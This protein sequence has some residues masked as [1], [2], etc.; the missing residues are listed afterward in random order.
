MARK[1]VTTN[2][3]GA[4]VYPVA[5][6]LS[7]LCMYDYIYICTSVVDVYASLCVCEYV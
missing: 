4:R 1:S 3:T 7:P 5:I 6:R 2:V